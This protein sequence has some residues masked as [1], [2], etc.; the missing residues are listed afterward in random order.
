M[1]TVA[2]APPA[3]RAT[4]VSASWAMRKAARSTPGGSGRSRPDTSTRTATPADAA[5]ATSPSRSAASRG[6]GRRGAA[7]PSRRRTSRT[8]RNSPSASFEASLM[9]ASAARAWSGCS[10]MRWRPTPAWTL[11]SEMLWASTSCSSW[12]I[13]SRSS[14]ARRSASSRRTR[15]AA[16]PRS[17]R[18]L[19]TSATAASTSNQAASPRI[20]WPTGARSRPNQWGSHR[21]RPPDGQRRPRLPPPPPPGGV[22]VGHDQ[23]EPDRALPVADDDV[24]QRREEG[25]LEHR[26]REPP[27]HG[28]RRRS[29]GEE[30]DAEGVERVAPGLGPV[31]GGE[32]GTDNLEE[33]DHD[34]HAQV[35]SRPPPPQRGVGRVG[36]VGARRA[37][38]SEVHGST[39]RPA[40]GGVIHPRLDPALPQ[41]RYASDGQPTIPKSYRPSFK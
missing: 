7:S 24:G 5:L 4:L 10:S 13:W 20:S 38:R 21:S 18:T 35:V 22:D 9:A 25:H 15:A 30:N 34:G 6:A 17:R 1:R 2:L 8:D 11:M 32:R 14:L 28:Q 23:A 37:G 39:L 19:T 36:R 33:P 31:V 26:H 29:G 12:A 16:I 3:C 41:P 40:A 27:A